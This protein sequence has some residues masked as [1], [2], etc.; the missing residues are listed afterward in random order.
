MK[1]LSD[2]PVVVHDAAQSG[3][4]YH[5]AHGFSAI[6]DGQKARAP[7]PNEGAPAERVR[8][9]KWIKAIGARMMHGGAYA[10]RWTCELRPTRTSP[11]K[12][13]VMH[14]ATRWATR[15]SWR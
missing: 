15:Y 8:K 10:P 6:K 14:N 4:K 2:I 9:P 1:R 11:C 13:R 7:K 3:Q 12:H 5:N